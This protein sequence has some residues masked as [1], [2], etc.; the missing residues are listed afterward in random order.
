MYVYNIADMI[1]V[2]SR[3]SIRTNKE[4]KGESNGDEGGVGGAEWEEEDAAG[5]EKDGDVGH[6][7]WVHPA[8]IRKPTRHHLQILN[9]IETIF[10]LVDDGT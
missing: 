9:I 3:C 4:S 10:V 6:N 5:R 8:K 7:Q 2:L 1:S